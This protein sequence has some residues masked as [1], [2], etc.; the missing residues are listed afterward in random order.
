M[1]ALSP[2][3]ELREVLRGLTRSELAEMAIWHA[4]QSTIITRHLMRPLADDAPPTLIVL[5]MAPARKRG[6]R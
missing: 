6:A 1:N 2:D 4:E 3:D 5:P